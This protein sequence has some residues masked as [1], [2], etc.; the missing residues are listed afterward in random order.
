MNVK[1]NHQIYND[2]LELRVLQL[3]RINE[4]T[5]EDKS[6]KIDTWAKLFKATTWEEIMMLA[7]KDS[8]FA[9]V[10]QEL[11]KSNSDERIRQ[12]CEAREDYF[13]R[14]NYQNHRVEEL[15]NENISIKAEK[16]QLED[17]KEQLEN[18]KEQL[19][20][21]NDHLKAELARLKAEQK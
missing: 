20:F 8:V 1:S 18:E 2:K 17:E 7:Q 9:S 21:E 4:A 14:L 11:Y 10:A 12:E 13:R 15:E 6:N 5:D 16:K 19:Q 3:K